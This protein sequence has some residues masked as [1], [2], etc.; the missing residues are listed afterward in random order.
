MYGET[1]QMDLLVQMIH[2]DVVDRG[3]VTIAYEPAVVALSPD[4]V[5]WNEM[6]EEGSYVRVEDES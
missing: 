4:S 2:D 3:W 6:F 1:F 5:T